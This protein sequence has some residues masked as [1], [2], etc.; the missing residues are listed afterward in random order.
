MLLRAGPRQHGSWQPQFTSDQ[1]VPR[2]PVWRSREQFF[3]STNDRSAGPAA[4]ATKYIYAVLGWLAA[5]KEAAMGSK[6]GDCRPAS[7][8]TKIVTA[9]QSEF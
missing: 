2:A 8:G 4:R 7:C 5:G 6:R 1:S 9:T 3:P